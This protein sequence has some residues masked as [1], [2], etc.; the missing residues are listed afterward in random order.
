MC[1]TMDLVA[2]T[3]EGPKGQVVIRRFLDWQ[4]VQVLSPVEG[5]DV[6]ALSWSPDGS[7]VALGT[8]YFITNVI[9]NE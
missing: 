9:F 7:S 2:T 3:S 1:K 5:G 6:G 8:R 4:K